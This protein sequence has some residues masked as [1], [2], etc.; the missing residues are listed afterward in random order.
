M[1]SVK[2]VESGYEIDT[3]PE[4]L[5]DG[6]FISRA[7]VRRLVDDRVDELRPDSSPS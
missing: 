6:K 2:F 7:V 1:S 5:P 3:T 4:L